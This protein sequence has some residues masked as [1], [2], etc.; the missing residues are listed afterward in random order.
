MSEQL[1]TKKYEI[2]NVDYS[3]ASLILGELYPEDKSFMS[4]SQKIFVPSKSEDARA[5]FLNNDFSNP[6]LEID[7]E[8]S[9]IKKILDELEGKGVELKKL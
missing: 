4:R 5:I 1:R 7:G 2:V 8:T 3:K 9:Q 6:R